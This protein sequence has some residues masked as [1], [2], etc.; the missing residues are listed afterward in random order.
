MFH[1]QDYVKKMDNILSNKKK[2]TIVKLKKDNLLSYAVS[3]GKHV[4][5]VLKK[6][7]ESNSMTEKNRKSLKPVGSRPGVMYGSCKVHKAGL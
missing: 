1:R 4:E 6:L 5:K 7:V 3:H 2:F